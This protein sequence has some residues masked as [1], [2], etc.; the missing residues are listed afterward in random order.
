MPGHWTEF[1]QTE[2][3]RNVTHARH[4]LALHELRSNFEPL[5]WHGR[6]PWQSLEQ[7]WFPG[8]HAD[9]GGGY[10]GTHL[11]DGGLQWL[12]SEAR[13]LGLQV[14]WTASVKRRPTGPD[15]VHHEIR[16]KFVLASP[17]VRR[18]LSR[19]PTRPVVL[20]SFAVHDSVVQRLWDA[21]S[22]DYGYW[23][24]GVNGALRN[25]DEESLRLLVELSLMAGQPAIVMPGTKG[26]ISPALTPQL[27]AWVRTLT[28]GDMTQA[29]RRIRLMLTGAARPGEDELEP[30]VRSFVLLVM[31]QGPVFVERF[32]REAAKAGSANRRVSDVVRAAIE[33]LGNWSNLEVQSLLC[34]LKMTLKLD[35]SQISVR[36]VF[37]R[38]SI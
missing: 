19:P 27:S 4:A 6:T 8:A 9:V 17:T 5:L 12:A 31:F 14:G 23:R 15:R 16:G 22:M 26:H 10:G 11:S 28:P 13:Q 35:E 1:H 25:A 3:P 36:P 38:S 24:P 29:H 21:P 34:A 7:V 37:A 33:K 20:E 30:M 32:C 18:Q 2:L